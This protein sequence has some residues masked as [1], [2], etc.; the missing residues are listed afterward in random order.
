MT[1][2]ADEENN[3]QKDEDVFDGRGERV[4]HIPVQVCRLDKR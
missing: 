2:V 3:E 1:L 4:H